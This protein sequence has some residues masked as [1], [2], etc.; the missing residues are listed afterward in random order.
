MEEISTTI[1]NTP[2]LKPFTLS[3]ESLD[4]YKRKLALIPLNDLHLKPS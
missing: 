1:R 3:K 2:L 4:I